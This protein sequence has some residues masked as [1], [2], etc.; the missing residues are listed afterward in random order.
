MLATGERVTFP[1][2]LLY[3]PLM[4]GAPFAARYRSKCPAASRA[5]QQYVK[6]KKEIHDVGV[7]ALRRHLFF[8]C[9]I[10]L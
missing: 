3:G 9:S 5:R 8:L 10:G 2:F 4:R 7:G 6:K 1:R